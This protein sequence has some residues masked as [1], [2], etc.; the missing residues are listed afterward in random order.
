MVE[1]AMV[2]LL[3]IQS[4]IIYKNRLNLRLKK[5]KT[6]RSPLQVALFPFGLLRKAQLVC[7]FWHAVSSLWHHDSLWQN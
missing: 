1:H 3:L 2:W 6:A 4:A 5:Q 7:H